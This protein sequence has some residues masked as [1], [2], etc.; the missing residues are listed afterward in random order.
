MSTFVAS[1]DSF[2]IP[3]ISHDCNVHSVSSALDHEIGPD[4]IV[5]TTVFQSLLG[6]LAA[7]QLQGVK[8]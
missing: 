5:K 7:Y 1:N 3:T 2:N 6:M 4:F 8:C